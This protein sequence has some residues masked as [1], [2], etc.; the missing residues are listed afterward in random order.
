MISKSNC[1]P[2]FPHFHDY[3]LALSTTFPMDTTNPAILGLFVLLAR[4]ETRLEDM[5]DQMQRSNFNTD[6]RLSRIEDCLRR[7][8]RSSEGIEGRIEDM[9][10][11]F[12]E[13]DSKL[14][15]IDTDM[16]T[17]GISDAIKE[18][19]DELSKEGPDLTAMNHNSNI[20]LAIKDERLSSSEEIIFHGEI[21]IWQ[22]FP[23]REAG[24]L[25]LSPYHCSTIHRSSTVSVTTY[26]SNTTEAITLTKL[27]LKVETSA[28]RL[29]GRL[30]G[31]SLYSRHTVWIIIPTHRL[32]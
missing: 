30:S 26:C 3:D 4:I 16:L 23:F 18:G 5:E 22:R 9:D 7:I 2:R 13:V 11:R 1:L 20:Y 29:F 32:Q 6:R 8:E 25:Q 27:Y 14:E 17:D 28:S 21:L 10:S 19:F 12:D 15:D 31:G 24:N